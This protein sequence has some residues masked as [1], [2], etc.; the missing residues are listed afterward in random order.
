MFFAMIS[1]MMFLG[2]VLYPLGWMVTTTGFLVVLYSRLHLILD[3][4]KLLKSLLFIIVGIGVSSP[5]LY[6]G[7][8]DGS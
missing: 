1:D 8:C 7:S 5:D 4:P 3:S 6:G 2:S